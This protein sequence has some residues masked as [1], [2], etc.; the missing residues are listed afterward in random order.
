MHHMETLTT[1]V[2][3]IAQIS[4]GSQNP[5]QYAPPAP[6]QYAS[7]SQPPQPQSTS[8]V[9]QVILNLSKVVGNFVEEQ[10]S[11]NV[12]LNQR[13][14]TVESTLNKMMD[15]FQNEIAQ[16]ID[17]LQYSISKL[18]NQHQVQEK[19]KFPSQTQQNPKGV[20][21]IAYLS[22]TTPKMDE[23]KVVITLRSG[24]K[25]EQPMPK[26]LDEAKEGQEEEPERIVINEDM[27][28]KS[29]PQPF[30][31]ALRGK[32]GVNNPIEILKC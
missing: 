10:K 15:G 18:T 27:M 31:Q 7:T 32:K 2:R 4:L 30:P 23:V 22:E 3:E 9:E 19:G 25:V 28:K 1:L 24:K 5:P 17:N 16:K 21:E 12:Q 13:I 8:P 14:D 11:V 20:L 29:M 26:P 6:S